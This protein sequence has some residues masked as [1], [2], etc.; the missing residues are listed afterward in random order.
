LAEHVRAEVELFSCDYDSTVEAGPVSKIWTSKPGPRERLLLEH[1]RS[2]EELAATLRARG[3]TV[4]VDVVWDYPLEDA[5]VKKAAA[6]E[7]WLVAKHVDHNNV[8]QRT[9][10]TNTDWALIRHCEVPLL[11]VKTRRIGVKP[12]VIAA[13]DPLHEH[14]KLAQL[15]DSIVR[16]ADELVLATGGVLHVVHALATPTRIELPADVRE[17]VAAKHR[18]AVADFLRRHRVPSAN[19]H[20]LEGPASTCLQHAVDQWQADF[21]VMGAVARTGS[22]KLFIGSMAER[23]IDR[24]PCDLV[25]L[26]PARLRRAQ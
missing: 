21:V 3:L 25:I 4:S 10:L 24:L 19:V 11:F 16:F 17:L 15:D 22:N 23:V 13:I 6:S 5:I 2:L 9:L 20:M 12:T 8:V 7:P 26:R 18:E 1:R 14:D